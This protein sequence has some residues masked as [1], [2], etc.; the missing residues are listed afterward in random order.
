MRFAVHSDNPVVSRMSHLR[1]HGCPFAVAGF[2]A[3]AVVCAINCVCF[4][5][6]LAHVGQKSIE[7]VE[8]SLTDGYATA[9]VVFVA[10]HLGVVTPRLHPTP[11]PIC[12]R[13]IAERLTVR[14]MRGTAA[15][16]F[17]A[18]ARIGKSSAQMATKHVLLDS[19][20]AA[21]PPSCRLAFRSRTEQHCPAAKRPPGEINKARRHGT[22]SI[23]VDP[24][25]VKTC[26]GPA[27]VPVFGDQPSRTS[28]HCTI[29]LPRMQ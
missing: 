12:A 27:M 26:G 25:K 9:T 24:S 19:T 16:P 3:L 14:D 23:A 4:A 2:I 13:P 22:I 18:S 29:I 1:L 15:F 21:T 20:N 10:R 17:P 5:W 6:T 11:N 7:A 28:N 8:P